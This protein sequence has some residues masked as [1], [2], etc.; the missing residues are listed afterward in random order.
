[1][2][3]L[4]AVYHVLEGNLHPSLP[5]TNFFV[6]FFPHLLCIQWRALLRLCVIP[7][8]RKY[9]HGQGGISWKWWINYTLDTQST[10]SMKLLL[11]FIQWNQCNDQNCILVGANFCYFLFEYS[12]SFEAP[13]VPL[14]NA[15]FM[16]GRCTLP[17]NVHFYVFMFLFNKPVCYLRFCRHTDSS[18]KGFVF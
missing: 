15:V 10:D 2:K 8:G 5:F 18:L 3:L 17:I 14:A 11:N 7:H 9:S 1:M 13:R 4:K 6:G 16:L 12:D